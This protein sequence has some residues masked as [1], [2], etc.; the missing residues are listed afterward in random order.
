TRFIQKLSKRELEVV[1]AVLAGYVSQK[2]LAES[3]NISVNTVKTHLK[4]I[5]QTTGISGVDALSLLFHGYAPAH[6]KITPKS[7]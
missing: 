4:N 6:P 5:Y 3:L 2:E 1:E 7:P